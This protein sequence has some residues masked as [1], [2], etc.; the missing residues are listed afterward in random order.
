MRLLHDVYLWHTG[1]SRV[2]QFSVDD[3]LIVIRK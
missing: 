1:E 2:E 3:K